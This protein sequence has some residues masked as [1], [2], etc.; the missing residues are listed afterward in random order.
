MTAFKEVPIRL[1]DLE[2]V[3]QILNACLNYFTARDLCEAQAQL[4]LHSKSPLTSEL[5][6]VYERMS[7]YLSDF[8]LSQYEEEHGFNDDTENVDAESVIEEEVVVE[9]EEV[10]AD[11]PLGTVEVNR[12]KGRRL[13]KEEVAGDRSLEN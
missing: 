3:R 4:R 9:E 2:D 6:R 11:N 5:E 13:T 7:G 12:Q 8:L 1:E 10:L